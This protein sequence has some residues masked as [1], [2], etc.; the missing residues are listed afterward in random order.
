MAKTIRIECPPVLQKILCEAIREYADAAYPPGG[1]EC[2]QVVRQA[3][4]DAAEKLE[5]D[6]AVNNGDYAELSRRL[7][8]HLKAASQFYVEQHQ[9]QELEPLLMRLLQGEVIGH[10]ELSSSCHTFI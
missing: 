8:T 10:A 5:T 9:C 1:S 3:L 7:R 2:G 4:M 6:F